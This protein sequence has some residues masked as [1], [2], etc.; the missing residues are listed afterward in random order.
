MITIIDWI[1]GILVASVIG[2]G[3]SYIS[4]RFGPHII[5]KIGG[6]LVAIIIT[7]IIELIIFKILWL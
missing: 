6:P 1:A 5:I 7:T 2:G 3:G 4:I